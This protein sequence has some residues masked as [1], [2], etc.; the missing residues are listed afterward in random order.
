MQV[1]WVAHSEQHVA[2][3]EGVARHQ[4]DQGLGAQLALEAGAHPTD[5]AAYLHQPETIQGQQDGVQ[6]EDGAETTAESVHDE[7]DVAPDGDC[8]QRDH[9]LHV[10]STE[11]EERG[12]EPGEVQPVHVPHRHAAC[13]ICE[14]LSSRSIRV[15]SR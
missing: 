2:R 7:G 12:A 9:R 11:D 1:E 14:M 15:R 3:L 4:R 13:S 6:D 5:H 10:E 8:S